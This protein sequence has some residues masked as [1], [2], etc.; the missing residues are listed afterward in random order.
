MQLPGEV[1]QNLEL[2]NMKEDVQIWVKA[3]I[4]ELS[5]KLVLENAKERF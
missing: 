2:R 5:L 3:P 4:S 1:T